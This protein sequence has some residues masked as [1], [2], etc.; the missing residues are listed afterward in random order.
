M[1]VSLLLIGAVAAVG[2]CWVLAGWPWALALFAVLA[3]V[4]GVILV[5]LAALMPDP[6]PKAG[7][8]E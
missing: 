7:G 6:E 8:A 2:S 3:C 4:A 1:G 5:Y